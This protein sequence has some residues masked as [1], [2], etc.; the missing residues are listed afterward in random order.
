[1]L[2]NLVYLG[3][4]AS[5]LGT[6]AYVRDTLRGTTKPNRVTYIIWAVNP[7]IAAFVSFAAGAG[8]A[9]LPV[10]ATGLGPLAVL[11][12]SIANKNSYWKLSTF[13]YFC[14]ACSIVA[15]FFWLA[16]AGPILPISLAIISDGFAVLPT[17]TKSWKYP[18]TETGIAYVL[19]LFCPLTSFA[20]IKTWDFPSCAFPAYLLVANIFLVLAVYRRKWYRF[21]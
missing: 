6:A 5:F 8:L 15:I 1:M 9:A 19:G 10:L 13:D 3:V 16:A 7:L 12:A 11:L 2:E 18:E 21:N 17:I 4:A 20:A 14:G